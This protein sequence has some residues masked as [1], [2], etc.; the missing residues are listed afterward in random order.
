MNGSDYKL[1]RLI[2]HIYLKGLCCP[3]PQLWAEL[4][5]RISS[6]PAF[7]NSGERYPPSLILGGWWES[8]ESE[9]RTRLLEQILFAYRH[10]AINEACDYLT[11][12]SDDEWH[13]MRG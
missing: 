9:K 11:S 5:N 7:S 13:K 10:G 1:I 12:L 4:G 8:S 6:G 2:D 3:M